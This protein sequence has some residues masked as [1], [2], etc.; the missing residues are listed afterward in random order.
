MRAGCS[1]ACGRAAAWRT[2]GTRRCNLTCWCRRRWWLRRWP[3]L[4]HDCQSP[5]SL[6]MTGCYIVWQAVSSAPRLILDV[7]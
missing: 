6:G 1:H 7:A 5:V 3:T 2:A 4:C